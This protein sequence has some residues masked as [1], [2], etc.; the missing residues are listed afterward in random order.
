MPPAGLPAPP[1][2]ACIAAASDSPASPIGCRN[3]VT[4]VTA[5]MATRDSSALLTTAEMARA[6]TLTI[7]RG[8]PGLALMENAGRAVAESVAARFVKGPVSVL[9]GP[10]NNGGDGF[11]AARLLAERGWPVSLFLMGGRERL[12]GDAAEA[13]SRW[14]G[15]VHPLTADGARHSLSMRS[16]G[17]GFQRMSRVLRPISSPARRG[18]ERPSSRSM[19][20]AA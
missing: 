18:T 2:R 17:P 13:A 19:C 14:P 6:D 1:G 16:S 5:M 12:T 9:C 11:V 8:T 10:G 4:I 3:R 7:E 20:Q 15:P